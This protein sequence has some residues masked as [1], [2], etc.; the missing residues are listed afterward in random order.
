MKTSKTT[1]LL[2]A[3]SESHLQCVDGC[4]PTALQVSLCIHIAK[5]NAVEL[6]LVKSKATPWVT[7]AATGLHFCSVAPAAVLIAAARHGHAQIGAK[8]WG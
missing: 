1:L 2:R 7:M 5:T 3:Y 6:V 8:G 4:V